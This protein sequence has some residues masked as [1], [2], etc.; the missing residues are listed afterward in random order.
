VLLA[1][2]DHDWQEVHWTWPPELSLSIGPGQPMFPAD[3]DGDGCTDL[4]APGSSIFLGMGSLPGV[5]VLY[6]KTDGTF[7]PESHLVDSAG[8]AALSQDPYDWT[9]TNVSGGAGLALVHVNPTAGRVDTIVPN[10]QGDWRDV[11]SQLPQ[12]FTA[13]GRWQPSAVNADNAADLIRVTVDPQGNLTGQTLVG[14][15]DG[16]LTAVQAAPSGPVAGGAVVGADTG[17]WQPES[18]GGRTSTSLIHVFD[19]GSDT[20]VQTLT[21]VNDGA[22]WVLTPGPSGGQAPGAFVP[23]STWQVGNTTGPDRISLSH[24]FIDGTGALLTV[25]WDSSAV[26]PLITSINNGSGAATD[27]TYQPAV[28]F[29]GTATVAG[30]DCRVPTSVLAANVVTGLTTRVGATSPPADS[31]AANYTV[32]DGDTLAT[33][34]QSV[35]KDPNQAPALFTLNQGHPEPDGAT[36]DNPE[37]LKPGWILQ[38]PVADSGTET[39]PVPG[40]VTTG[41]DS[42]SITYGCPRYSQQLKRFLGWTQTQTTHDA[43]VT[44]GSATPATGRPGSIEDVTR[45]IDTRSGIVQTTQDTITDQPPPGQSTPK[46][47]HRTI[48][49][50]EP[51]GDRAPYRDRVS[52]TTSGDCDG[53]A[54]CAASTT[55]VSYDDYGN[56]EDTVEQAAGSGQSRDTSTN[57]VHDDVRWL[58]NRAR[59]VHT[60]SPSSPDEPYRESLTCYD[61]DTTVDCRELPPLGAGLPTRTLAWNGT[62]FQQAST[63]TYDQWGN[64]LTT[65]DARGNTTKTTFDPERHLDPISTCQA[66][67]T[68][69][70]CTSS[71]EP[72]DR[73]ANAPTTAI[74]VN[75]AT[76]RLGYDLL[77]RLHVV[78]R[79]TGAR[80]VTD[81]T[82]DPA[83]GTTSTSTTD[84]PGIPATTTRT[85]TDGLQHAYRVEKPGGD[86]ARVSVTSTLYLDATLTGVRTAPHF[87]DQLATQFDT[88]S[89]DPLSRPIRV[90]HA[91]G[92]SVN[93]SYSITPD[94]FDVVTTTD[95]T[96]HTTTR[97]YDGWSQLA[98]VDQPSVEHPD[99]PATTL[100]AYDFVGDLFAVTD[101]HHNVVYYER[102]QLGQKTAEHDPDRGTTTY[103]YDPAGNLQ[104]VTDARGRTLHYTHDPLN[105]VDSKTDLATGEVTTWRYDEPG[106][107]AS[108]GRLTTVR[109]PSGAGC[110]NDGTSRAVSYDTLGNATSDTR[111]VTGVTGTFSSDFDALG[112]MT[113]ITYPDK[114][115]VGYGYDDAGH[116]ATVDGYVTGIQYDADDLPHTIR[117]ANDTLSTD[118]RNPQRAWLLNQTLTP[119]MGKTTGPLFDASYTHN[120]AGLVTS[121]TSA[122]N[123][124]HESYRYD[125]LGQLT[126]VVDT[127][128]GQ[129]MQHLN[130]NDIGNIITNS[131]VGDYIYPATRTCT[132]NPDPGNT[133]AGPH[134]VTTAGNSTYHY[135]TAGNTLTTDDAGNKQQLTWNTDG[136]L[137]QLVDP[138]AGTIHNTY[139]SAGTRVREDTPQGSTIYLAGLTEEN[140]VTAKWTD[141]IYAGGRL[142]AAHG[143]DHTSW[144]TLDRQNSTGALTD[145]RGAI[146]AQANY[147]PWGQTATST[148]DVGGI[149]YTGHRTLTGTDLIDMTARDYN[150]V[151]GRM[152]SPDSIIPNPADPQTLNRYTYVHNDPVNYTDPT[153]HQECDANC[154]SETLATY[155]PMPDDW[156]DLTEE[157]PY[158]PSE[159]I[160]IDVNSVAASN[161]APLTQTP[162]VDPVTGVNLTESGPLGPGTVEE[163]FTIHTGQDEQLTTARQARAQR[164]LDTTVTTILEPARDVLEALLQELIGPYERTGRQSNAVN[165]Q[166]LQVQ[167]TGPSDGNYPHDHHIFS[168]A[169]RPFFEAAGIDIDEHTVTIPRD[170]HLGNVH[171]EWNNEWEE[172]FAKDPFPGKAAIEDQAAIMMERHNLQDLYIHPYG[173]GTG[174]LNFKR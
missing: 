168:R 64:Q 99:A 16:H 113:A 61:G 125:P 143:P 52:S 140:P 15:G 169:G 62:T 94:G 26:Q 137:E 84:A 37:A 14:L 24:L 153:G 11:V 66:I 104:D 152:L 108:V 13:P 124:E 93:T 49:T 147:S 126:D 4:V 145:N 32:E 22:T 65:T 35:L 39:G 88:T 112:R 163:L 38:L 97:F 119:G 75:G 85:F 120:G 43:A 20:T 128:T 53:A 8:T 77:G 92:T 100:Y 162:T 28:H 18:L 2:N 44:A 138:T 81:Y 129:P 36:L 82:T 50:F 30:S 160:I 51:L 109:D 142:V 136:Y 5:T 60:S 91:D 139:D 78:T 158:G 123:G 7:R 105:R 165:N 146:T 87:A 33:I 25:G 6:G 157:S 27:V 3:F 73:V 79:P 115:H 114:I 98:R 95:E 130:Y 107:G 164:A 141:Y 122:S 80:T 102:N 45:S 74:D 89:Y 167:S 57:F 67:E 110:D 134:A 96:G 71:P 111:C 63:A 55:T 46:P 106:H 56:I 150:P 40:T 48:S 131:K 58:H 31:F 103:G 155:A 76:T 171:P 90:I 47:L 17:R 156:G 83:T 41:P 86:G 166:A 127:T 42:S 118:T 148:G 9:P 101:P 173:E 19:R 12:E 54:N 121:T 23:S 69:N 72:W 172:F 68:K 149:G 161:K 159:V 154:Q 144:Y 170:E 34:A 70:Q 29:T 1:V 21:P 135:D 59:L 133:C 116:L 132:A 117:Y 151:L 10:P 174:A